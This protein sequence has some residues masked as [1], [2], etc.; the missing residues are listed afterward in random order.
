MRREAEGSA[1]ELV[2][3]AVRPLFNAEIDKTYLMVT[4]PALATPLKTNPITTR[5][6]PNKL[7]RFNIVSLL[8]MVISVV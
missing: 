8:L 6:V 4:L 7:I 2:G 1:P 3:P 5:A